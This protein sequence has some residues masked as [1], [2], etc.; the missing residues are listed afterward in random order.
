MQSRNPPLRAKPLPR[1]RPFP[2]SGNFPEFA[3][4]L[5]ASALPDLLEAAAAYTS[6]MEGRPHFTRPHLMRHVATATEQSDMNREDS[7]RSFGTLLR[8]GKIAKVK[9]G[10]FAITDSSHYL[11]EARRMTR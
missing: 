9:R 1:P 6:C 5:G 10:Q 2:S 11:A 3:E 4:H 8:Q 7:M